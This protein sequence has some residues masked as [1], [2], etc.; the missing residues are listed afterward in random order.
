MRDSRKWNTPSEAVVWDGE[1]KGML[2]VTG[3]I[4]TTMPPSVR[5]VVL[6]TSPATSKHPELPNSAVCWHA[7][8][9]LTAV[10]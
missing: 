7:R 3:R 1:L 10:G 5:P 2:L 9:S 6:T 4:P 8:E